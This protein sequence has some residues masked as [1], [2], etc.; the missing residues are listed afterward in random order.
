MNNSPSTPPR[1]YAPENP[2]YSPDPLGEVL[3]SRQLRNPPELVRLNSVAIV[4]IPSL[5][6]FL[7]FP[8]LSD[9][10]EEIDEHSS[11]RALELSLSKLRSTES[12]SKN[13]N[14]RPL[15]LSLPQRTEETLYLVGDSEL[16]N[17]PVL[18][19]QDTPKK[20]RA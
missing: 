1:R 15:T 11:Q 8:D 2:Y 17:A 6:E 19:T 16:S 5:P 4:S 18:S 7:A 10:T 3:Y 14:K 20:K 13:T 9:L 12:S